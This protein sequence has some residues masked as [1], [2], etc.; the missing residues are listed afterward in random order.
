MVLHGYYAFTS[1]VHLVYPPPPPICLPLF[2]FSGY[3]GSYVKGSVY[4]WRNK[5]IFTSNYINPIHYISIT[6][7]YQVH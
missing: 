3:H 4:I 1:Y 5:L 2:T 7:P 6:Y